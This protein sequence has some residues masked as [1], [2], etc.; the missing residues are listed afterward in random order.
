M[1]EAELKKKI[2]GGVEGHPF[3]KKIKFEIEDKNFLGGS[4][5][6]QKN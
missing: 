4:P 3:S 2:L 6:P 1:K 5:H